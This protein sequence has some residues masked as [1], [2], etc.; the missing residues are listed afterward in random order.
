MAVIAPWMEPFLAYLIRQELP[1]DQTEARCIVRDLK[2]TRSMRENFI[3]KAQP[4]S[5]KGVS[6]KR[7]GETFWLKFMPDSAG[8]TLQPS[9]CKQGLPYRILLA[10]GP[11]R[12]SGLSA[13]MCWLP[14]IRQPK[15]HAA[16]HPTNYTNYLAFRG[17][18]A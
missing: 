9:P 7:K 6:P 18:G 8:T 4:E 17:L 1:E 2:P 14:V 16:Y 12:R 5:F 13:T 11:G 3:R 15:P 10:N